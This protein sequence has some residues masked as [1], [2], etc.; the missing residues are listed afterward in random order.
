METEKTTFTD[1]IVDALRK[2][3]TELEE[4]QVQA[5]LGK[6]EALDKYEESKKKFKSFI[7]DTKVKMEK[8]KDSLGDLHQ[9]FDELKV[10][11]ALGKAETLESF[12]EQK[13]KI[14]NSLREIESKI[15][16]NATVNR[17]YAS[18]LIE[19]E[20]FK[21][22]LEWLEAKFK[23]GSQDFADSFNKQ[24]EEFKAFVNRMSDKFSS[25]K[26]E[27]DTSRWDNFQSEMSEAFDHVKKAFSKS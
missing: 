17:V 9:K 2:A 14:L 26:E 19:I 6:K 10:Q 12:Q 18:L 1:Y 5:S 21:V 13:K 25:D 3:A 7:H 22:R 24:K 11:L 27:D 16:S 15:K 4:L 8:G 23:E 20:K